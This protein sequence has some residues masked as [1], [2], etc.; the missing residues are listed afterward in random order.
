MPVKRQNGSEWKEWLSENAPR[1]LA[2]AQQR[3]D[4]MAEAED[5]LQDSLI[6]LWHY[7][8]ERD[9]RPPDLPLAFSVLRYIGLDRGR[10][11]GRRDKRDQ[12]IVQFQVG[13]D[14]WLDT[15]AEQS[16]EAEILRCAV[17]KLPEK[18]REVLTLKIWGGL[19]FAEIGEI[20]SLS[21]N[22]AASR[23]RYALEQ[24]QKKLSHLKDSRHG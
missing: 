22:T 6:K 4:S 12:K 5:M 24:L 19:T 8:E 14:L 16:E 3:C 9:Y 20:L 18:L 1:L 10:S 21:N 2:Y 11:K 15:P 13:S 17:E 23:Y 7:Q